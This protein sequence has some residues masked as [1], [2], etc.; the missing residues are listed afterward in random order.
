MLGT[1]VE[2]PGIVKNHIGDNVIC[3]Y[4]GYDI[5]EQPVF[6]KSSGFDPLMIKV[7]CRE[8]GH[9]YLVAPAPNYKEQGNDI[10][11]VG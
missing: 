3:G 10:D 6:D 2:C 5:I 11:R 9:E 7:R 4:E 8:C 1:V